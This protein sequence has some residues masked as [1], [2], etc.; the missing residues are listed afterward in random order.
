M[1]SPLASPWPHVIIDSAH[2]QPRMCGLAEPRPQSPKPQPSVH[3]QAIYFGMC[4][5]GNGLDEA[6]TEIFQVIRA[7]SGCDA[8]LR[9]AL[10]TAITLYTL[11]YLQGKA[12]EMA[13]QAASDVQFSPRMVDSLID[14]VLILEDQGRLIYANPAVERLLGW[15]VALLFG[16]P[17]TDLL[18]ERL[19]GESVTMFKEWMATDPPLRSP[20]PIRMTMLRADGSEYRSM[21]ASS[22]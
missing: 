19:R 2:G 8:Q 13:Q 21:S 16:A 1:L 4:A 6:S 12:I 5:W 10:F 9:R 18:P 20:A 15:N 7:G 3:P 14:A 22:S 17:L 11:R